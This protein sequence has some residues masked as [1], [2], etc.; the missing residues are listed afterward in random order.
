[1]TIRGTNLQRAERLRALEQSRLDSL[2]AELL[3]LEA[4]LAEH[5]ARLQG[6]ISELHRTASRDWSAS[7]GQHRQS[8]AWIEHLQA[9]AV[10]LQ[11]EAQAIALERDELRTKTLSQRSK[12]RGWDSLLQRLLAQ[13]A[14][15]LERTESLVA[16]DRYL[17]Q[18]FS[19]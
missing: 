12:V 7:L 19:R 10:A 3:K 9:S 5:T 6:V 8:M 2:A 14:R 18:H 11:Q 17:N 15:E 16:D 1:M 4:R 13:Q